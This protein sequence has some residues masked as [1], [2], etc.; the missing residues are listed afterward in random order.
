[1]N[2]IDNIVVISQNVKLESLS[3]L[4]AYITPNSETLIVST[5]L[6]FEN[7]SELIDTIFECKCKYINFSDLR[8]L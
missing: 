2:N 4:K 1:M 3:K 6:I 5:Q 8:S 7:E